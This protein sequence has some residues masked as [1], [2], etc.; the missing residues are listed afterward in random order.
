MRPLVQEPRKTV[1]TGISRIGVPAVE[2]HVLQRALGGV[3]L[4][5]GGQRGRVGDGVAERDALAGVG[6]PGDERA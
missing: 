5:A 1:S 3:A 4:G 6:A 2:A